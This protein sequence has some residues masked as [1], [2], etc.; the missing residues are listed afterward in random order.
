MK[1]HQN[2]NSGFMAYEW[3]YLELV[4]KRMGF[5]NNWVA[6]MMKC[7]SLVNYSILINNEPSSIIH[8]ARGIRQGDPFS[9][10]LFLFYTKGLHSLIQHVAASGQIRG[11]SISKKGPW[12]THPFFT[13]NSLLFCRASI[14]E[15]HKIQD[16]LS[17]YE[18][19]SGQ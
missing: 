13:D 11:V 9:P 7:I 2:G 19:A 17:N 14:V 18:S 16:F 8:P 4:M 5:A 3:K 15:C 10:Y 12:L 6:L 1:H